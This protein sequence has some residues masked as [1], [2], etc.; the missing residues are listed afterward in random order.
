MV[1]VYHPP[2]PPPL[3]NILLNKKPTLLQKYD[4]FAA[5]TPLF[6]RKVKTE[7]L[8]EIIYD[9]YIFFQFFHSSR[10]EDMRILQNAAFFCTMPRGLGI[11]VIS[12]M[13]SDDKGLIQKMYN[14][15]IHST[16][17]CVIC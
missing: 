16:K 13:K 9:P 7:K 5:E 3:P 17:L 4:D 8:G 11:I 1:A 2:S 6:R 12:K 14:R 10:F 15:S